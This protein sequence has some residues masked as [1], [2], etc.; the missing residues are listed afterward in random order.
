MSQQQTP[1]LRLRKDYFESYLRKLFNAKANDPIVIDRTNAVGKFIHAHVTECEYSH[2][3]K[4]TKGCTPIILSNYRYLYQDRRWLTF[5]KDDVE[6]IND[7]ID[8]MIELESREMLIVGVELGHERQTII[9]VLLKTIIGMEKFEMIKKDD[10]R[11]RMKIEENIRSNVHLFGVQKDKKR[12][13]PLSLLKDKK[14][15]NRRACY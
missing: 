15:L 12:N 14:M 9:S 13:S 4:A 10:Y 6:K 11:R 7:F 2:P 5:R 8:A 1:Y 3:Q